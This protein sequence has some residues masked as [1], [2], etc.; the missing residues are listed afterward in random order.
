MIS[1]W[2]GY[3]DAPEDDS[4]YKWFCR[5]YIHI[6]EPDEVDIVDTHIVNNECSGGGIVKGKT[7]HKTF[8]FRNVT[9]E[10][11]TYE[12]ADGGAITVNP[13]HQETDYSI[14]L[15]GVRLL[16]N[17]NSIYGGMGALALDE[18]YDYQQNLVTL[19]ITNCV[20]DSNHASKSAAIKWVG[21]SLYITNTTFIGNTMNSESTVTFNQYY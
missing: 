7:L 6:E 1:N 3:N 11:N 2:N 9:I 15:D 5:A 14:V 10:S 21:L 16:S 12:I 20:F 8:S 4:I 13:V 18:T 17:N 19:N